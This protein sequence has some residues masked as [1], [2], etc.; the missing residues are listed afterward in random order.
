M[1]LLLV[2]KYY[3]Y[4]ALTKLSRGLW[5]FLLGSNELIVFLQGKVADSIL[6]DAS[7]FMFFSISDKNFESR[8]AK[9]MT[10][11]PRL[12]VICSKKCSSVN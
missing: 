9:F 4:P 5:Q 6:M 2:E 11:T 10:R 8:V 7:I 3:Q 12:R 1:R